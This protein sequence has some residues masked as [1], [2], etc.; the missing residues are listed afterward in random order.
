MKRGWTGRFYI[1]TWTGASYQHWKAGP[2]HALQVGFLG[3]VGTVL[4]THCS[5]H[6]IVNSCGADSSFNGVSNQGFPCLFNSSTVSRLIPMSS[7]S[8]LEAFCSC[9]LHGW[10]L[11]VPQWALHP[12]E[13]MERAPTFRNSGCSQQLHLQTHAK[14]FAVPAARMAV[15]SS[16]L[17]TIYVLTPCQKRFSSNM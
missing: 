9:S 6:V 16:C 1:L 17:G 2:Y 15:H 12:E 5:I 13:P 11:S 14:S 3:R 4:G 10:G 8:S 7:D